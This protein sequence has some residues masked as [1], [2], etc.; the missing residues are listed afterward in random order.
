[1]KI[2]FV[3]S[4]QEEVGAVSRSLPIGNIYDL[5]LSSGKRIREERRD[6]GANHA[7]LSKL[8]SDESHTEE[9]LD[10]VA[11]LIEKHV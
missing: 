3:R 7:Q 10:K 1:M 6:V 5:C 4:I 2:R 8:P 11:Q 9:H